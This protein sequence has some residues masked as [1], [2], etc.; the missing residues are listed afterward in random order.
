MTVNSLSQSYSVAAVSLSFSVRQASS[1]TTPAA[2]AP[3]EPRTASRAEQ[4]AELRA[5]RRGER[6]AEALFG[7]LD[8]DQDGAITAQEFTE[9]AVALLRRARD[10]QR[11]RGH[12]GEGHDDEG[13]GHHE[14]RGVGRLE[15]QLE[16]AFGRVDANDDGAIDR[17][18][19]TAALAAAGGRRRGEPTSPAEPTPPA[20]PAPPQ[21][22]PAA[23]AT[24]VSFSFTFVS[25]AV[26][27]Y[28][29]LQP[30][31]EPVT[32]AAPAATAAT[33]AGQTRAA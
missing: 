30:P 15:R 5:E 3:A 29:A 10:R 25:I 19:L 6:G 24:T 20:E 28:T 9:G 26:Q 4:R 1:S 27:R 17:D 32:S 8:A 23:A 21:D 12:D 18:E 7:A 11:V 22:A 2:A 13:H 31:A 14:S 16:K 33:A